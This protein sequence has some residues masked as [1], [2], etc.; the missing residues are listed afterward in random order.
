MEKNK[1]R[2]DVEEIENGVL[3]EVNDNYDLKTILKQTEREFVWRDQSI[4]ALKSQA[5]TIFG[6]ASVVIPLFGTLQIF[7][8]VSDA[9][10]VPYAIIIALM[11]ILYILLVVFSL[12]VLAATKYYG[13]I[14]MDWEDLSKAYYG[15][16][17]RDVIL[18]EISA[19]LHA[20]DENLPLLQM[21]KKWSKWILWIFP[22]IVCLSLVA[23][24][25]SKV[26]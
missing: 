15:K 6:T 10:K 26:F 4:E 7:S 3:L 25:L 16:D 17:Q 12:K 5:R 2:K 14:K 9:V 24:A 22:A 1:D 11:L 13:P 21:K 18:M 8:Q 19:N 23:T 20:H